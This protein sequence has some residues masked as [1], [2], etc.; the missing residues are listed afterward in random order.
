VAEEA[1]RQVAEVDSVQKRFIVFAWAAIAAIP[2]P[3]AAQPRLS[4]GH[5][6]LQGTYDLATLTPLERPAGTKA[7]L[8]PEEAAK[9][10]KDAAAQ[11]AKSN[12]AISG[13]R[14]A[15]PKG[16]DGSTGPAGGVGG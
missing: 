14:S 9:L 1:A 5:P 6:D 11:R 2:F 4:D 13:D 7:V 16:G 12:E 10:E 15:P 8:T 3:V